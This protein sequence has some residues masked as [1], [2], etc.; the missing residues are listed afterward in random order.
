MEVLICTQLNNPIWSLPT[1]TSSANGPGTITLPSPLAGQLSEAR[2]IHLW[3]DFID[4]IGRLTHG[5]VGWVR[6]DEQRWS[7]C[8]APEIPLHFHSLLKYQHV[9]APEAVEAIWK[10]KAGDAQVEPYG[11]GGGAALLPCEDVSIRGHEV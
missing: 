10:S 6:A 9:P 4:T 8:G 11:S 7:G 1:G 2:C 3:E 5:R